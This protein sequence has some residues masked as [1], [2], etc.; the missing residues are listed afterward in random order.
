MPAEIMGE[1]MIILKLLMKS[2]I[3]CVVCCPFGQTNQMQNNCKWMF[4]YLCYYYSHD[5][6]I[7]FLKF[8]V[9]TTWFC[10]CVFLWSS[11]QELF[12]RVAFNSNYAITDCTFALWFCCIATSQTEQRPH[13]KTTLLIKLVR[14]FTWPLKLGHWGRG[15]GPGGQLI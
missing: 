8:P 11:F 5:I 9:A 3:L 4:C 7:S 6:G 10:S 2:A 13:K 15:R 14:S 12:W 1:I